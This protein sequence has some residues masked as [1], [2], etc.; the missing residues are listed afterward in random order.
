[1]STPA[2]DRIVA[3]ALAKVDE[4]TTTADSLNAVGQQAPTVVAPKMEE[5]SKENPANEREKAV[6]ERTRIP[7]SIPN[8]HLAVPDIP[9]FHT[10]WFLSKNVH[11][12]LRAGYEYVNPEEVEL[13]AYGL[14]DDLAGGGSS[15]L[16]TRIS[17][18]ASSQVDNTGQPERLYL[19]KLRQE[20]WDDDQK[21]IEKANDRIAAALRGGDPVN[22]SERDADYEQHKHIPEWAPQRQRGNNNLFVK[23]TNRR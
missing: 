19:M 22:E 14:A 1:M 18:I 2:Q 23:K 9:G 17:H 21:L 6:T 12:A 4:A 20:W 15:D 16:G 10:H 3:A 7:M 11:R 8:Q 13:V 5:L